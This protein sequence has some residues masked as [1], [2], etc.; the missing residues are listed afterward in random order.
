M[1]STQAVDQKA[2][3]SAVVAADRRKLRR[4]NYDPIMLDAL[5]NQDKLVHDG[6]VRLLQ[7]LGPKAAPAVPQLI[8]DVR[9]R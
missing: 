2:V 5:S 8:G 6:G 1:R 4:P 9:K 3:L 7:S